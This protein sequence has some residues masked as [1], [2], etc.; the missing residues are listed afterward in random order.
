MQVENSAS[1]SLDA[2]IHPRCEPEIAF[3]LKDSLPV[4][5]T[6]ETAFDAIEAVAPAIEII[7]F[8]YENFRFSLPDVIADNASS[9]AFVLG[10]WRKPT[11]HLADAEVALAINEKVCQRGSTKDI[12]GNPLRAL[13]SAT[14]LTTLAGIPLA[15]G[16]ILLAG[17]ATA[18][19]PIVEGM[20]V[21]ATVANIGE[22]HFSV[23][24]GQ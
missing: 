18:A 8:R 11:S 21:K 24:P 10:E 6:P 3:L 17:A 1:I 7:D 16:S 14:R 9:A 15:S 22:V 5:A 19:E 23:L 13:I 2:L 20:R 12:L 4:D